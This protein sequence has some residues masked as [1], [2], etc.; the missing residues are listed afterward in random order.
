[1]YPPE[2]KSPSLIALL[3]PVANIATAAGGVALDFA[4]SAAAVEAN[5]LSL[6]ERR[7]GTGVHRGERRDGTVDGQVFLASRDE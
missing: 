6:P 3:E 7:G 2:P 4:E 5:Y 1:V